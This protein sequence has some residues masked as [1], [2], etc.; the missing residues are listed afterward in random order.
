MK[1]RADSVL[2][3]YNTSSI[4]LH[5][6]ES[7]IL[8]AF[9]HLWSAELHSHFR[10]VDNQIHLRRGEI[11]IRARVHTKLR[12]SR[13]WTEDWKSKK[14]KKSWQVWRLHPGKDQLHQQPL[15]KLIIMRDGVLD[16]HNLLQVSLPKQARKRQRERDREKTGLSFY[17]PPSIQHAIKWSLTRASLGGWTEYSSEFTF[18]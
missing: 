18:Q 9:I 13:Y 3:L 16:S 8:A 12:V 10:Q 11:H 6:T 4:Q 1:Q 17:F 5:R 2:Y 14:R 15:T 7:I